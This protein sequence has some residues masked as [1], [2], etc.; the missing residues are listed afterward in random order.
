[1]TG[2]YTKVNHGRSRKEW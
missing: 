1:M 2:K